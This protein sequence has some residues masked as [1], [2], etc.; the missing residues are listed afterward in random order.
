MKKVLKKIVAQFCRLMVMLLDG[1]CKKREEKELYTYE[2]E[3][4]NLYKPPVYEFKPRLLCDDNKLDLS[5]I[6]PVYN[7][8]KYIRE[9]LDS[10]F[11]NVT[12][13]K[14]EVIIV[15]DGSTDDSLKIVEEYKNNNLKILKQRNKGAASARNYALNYATGEYIAFIDSDDYVDENY[16]QKLLS[17]AKNKNCDAVRCGFYRKYDRK[18]FPYSME[19]KY[20]EHGIKEDILKMES[21]AWGSVMKRNIFEKISFPDG[22]WYEDKIMNPLIYLQAKDVV[23]IPDCLYY[24]RQHEKNISKKV[25]HSTNYKCLCQYYLSRYIIEYVK[26]SG[27]AIDL[28]LKRVIMKDV[29]LISYTRFENLPISM[30][31]KIFYLNASLVRKMNIKE[32]QIS[33]KIEKY[34]LRCFNKDN[35]LMYYFVVRYDKWK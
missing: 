26:K 15:D 6:I 4:E 32:E 12:S 16:I 9:C 8:E 11:K 23:V 29:G 34:Y 7:S 14:F 21:I 27:G 10:I 25:E 18:L 13:Y 35:F 28:V 19:Y 24:Y 33:N 2:K 5:I 20:Y 22:Y 30:Q 17:E 1:N 3:I 31:K